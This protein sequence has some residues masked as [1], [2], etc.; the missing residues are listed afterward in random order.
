MKHLSRLAAI[1]LIVVIAGCSSTQSSTTDTTMSTPSTA[2]SP[3]AFSRT[4]TEGTTTVQVVVSPEEACS[5]GTVRFTITQAGSSPA[6][7]SHDRDGTVVD[8]W[9]LDLDGNGTLDVAAATRSAGSGGYGAIVWY[10][11]SDQ[12]AEE[13]ELIELTQ[14][15]REKYRGRDQYTVVSG[16]LYREFPLYEPGDVLAEPS[17]GTIRYQ[18]D[19]DG[20]VWVLAP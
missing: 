2:Q 4:L 12:G 20:G 18:Y 7:V 10:E 19:F 11:L 3:C 5:I 8:A 14:D 9:L 1:G 16:V 15:Q 13:R 6:E 17:G